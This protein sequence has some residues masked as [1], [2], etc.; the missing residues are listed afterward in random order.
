MDKKT[1]NKNDRDLLPIAFEGP[2]EAT[3][4]KQTNLEC[5]KM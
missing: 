3:A 1:T 2:V 5:V 4:L